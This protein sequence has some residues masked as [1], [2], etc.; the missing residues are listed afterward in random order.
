MCR[1]RGGRGALGWRG[2]FKGDSAGVT[3]GFSR[4]SQ[5]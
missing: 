1:S 2:G 5:V 4:A 3:E